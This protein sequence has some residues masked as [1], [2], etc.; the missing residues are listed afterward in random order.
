M[1]EFLGEP[2]KGGT[3]VRRNE[4]ERRARVRRIRDLYLGAT[5]I[6]VCPHTHGQLLKLL[7]T[8]SVPIN[9]IMFSFQEQR[10]PTVTDLLEFKKAANLLESMRDSFKPCFCPPKTCPRSNAHPWRS[11]LMWIASKI[12]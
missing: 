8:A 7:E 4:K 5:S 3:N 9:N 11:F 2:A 1:D 10:T 12:S 6:Y